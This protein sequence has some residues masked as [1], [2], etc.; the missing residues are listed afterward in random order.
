M[1]N[2]E[3]IENIM[4][5]LREG[6][7]NIWKQTILNLLKKGSDVVP[8]LIEAIN[9]NH[10]DSERWNTLGLE[11]IRL[12]S[13]NNAKL[14]FDALL[15]KEEE[16]NK[17]RNLNNLGISYLGLNL[18]EDAIRCFQEAYDF[19]IKTVGEKIAKTL[20]A[21]ANLRNTIAHR[22]PIN[23]FKIKEQAGSGK[24]SKFQEMIYSELLLGGL[25]AGALIYILIAVEEYYP[26]I[27]G[28]KGGLFVSVIILIICLILMYV[29][30]KKL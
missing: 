10:Y 1:T 4:R 18:V 11:Y 2:G 28:I 21:W 22:M 5:N 23:Q 26:L 27:F 13:Y 30:K 29:F 24:L 14:L 17:G 16:K 15:K 25:L 20:P 8:H 12:G 3:E 19:D 6:T 7:E 9:Q